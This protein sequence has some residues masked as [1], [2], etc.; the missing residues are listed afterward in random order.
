MIY[1]IRISFSYHTILEK[2][3]HSLNGGLRDQKTN[4]THTHVHLSTQSFSVIIFHKIHLIISFPMDLLVM[5]CPLLSLWN[6]TLTIDPLGRQSNTIEI[7]SKLLWG[8]N[9]ITSYSIL[10]YYCS[11]TQQKGNLQIMH[12]IHENSFGYGN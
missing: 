1:L 12:T 11:K 7:I 4:I 2:T 10:I 9:E 8:S 5:A 3:E 6:A